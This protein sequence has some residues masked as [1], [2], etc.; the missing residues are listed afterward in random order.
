MSMAMINIDDLEPGM[1]LAEDLRSP[2][3]RLI[4]G[5][6]ELLTQAHIRTC[7]AW[8]VLAADIANVSREE[9]EARADKDLDPEL[10]EY[11]REVAREC[12]LEN[13]KEFP[14]QRELT[15]QFV[16]R[17]ARR[18]RDKTAAPRKER[19]G[20][21]ELI[22][23]K[24]AQLP[25]PE[26]MISSR[27]HLASLPEV[28]ARIIDALNDP[29]CSATHIAEVVGRDSSLSARLL[30]LVNSP[31][32]GFPRQVESLPRAV[33]LVGSRPLLTLAVGVSAVTLF[34]E[35]PP[36]LMTMRDFWRHSMGCALAARHL[37]GL[38]PGFDVERCFSGALMHD[39]GRLAMLMEY[40]LHCR[41][42]L[43][44]S[45]HDRVPEYHMERQEWGFD[46]AK[47]S[48]AL[49]RAWA[50]PEPLSAAV[51]QHHP[52][53]GDV[54]EGALLHVADVISH[55]LAAEDRAGLVPPLDRRAWELLG[56]PESVFA[57]VLSQVAHQMEDAVAAFFG[58]SP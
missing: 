26:S 3:G 6:G 11:C 12:F 4:L 17:L 1:M 13:G 10:L 42:V 55:A 45:Y 29:Y 8:G 35:I 32:Y 39:I 5:A 57:R 23:P 49:L 27:T 36:S 48:A 16:L 15:R 31:F 51:E 24:L 25:D 37:A 56:L 30:R 53:A 22:A 43:Y 58:S 7:K 9:V 14:A 38:L 46:H 21:R 20:P 18:E 40:P 41:T 50:L 2:Q 33:A 28:Y 44:R 47:V 52:G 19:K 54:P 34:N